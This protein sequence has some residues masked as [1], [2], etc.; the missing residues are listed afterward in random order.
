L[1]AVRTP[2]TATTHPPSLPD[3]LPISTES[4]TGV[5]ETSSVIDLRPSIER[6]R[7]RR[8]GSGDFQPQAGHRARPRWRIVRALYSSERPQD[9]QTS[10]STIGDVRGA[11]VGDPSPSRSTANPTPSFRATTYDR[12]GS[13][14]LKTTTASGNESHEAASTSRTRSDSAYRSS[15]SR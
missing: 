15:W 14:V 12:A 1:A 7:A 13:S 3:A 9:G 11:S 8:S 5:P 6:M 4:E 2:A 10:A